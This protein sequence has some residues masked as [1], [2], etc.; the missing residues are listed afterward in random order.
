MS[1]R[2]LQTRYI[3]LRELDLVTGYKDLRSCELTTAITILSPAFIYRFPLFVIILFVAVIGNF[4][5]Q[6][7]NWSERNFFMDNF[8]VTYF[9]AM[10]YLHH[11]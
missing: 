11:Q 8:I 1:M 5:Y 4:I 2:F 10:A 3:P 9:S 6:G 7:F